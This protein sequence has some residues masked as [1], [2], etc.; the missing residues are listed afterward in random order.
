MP[1][2]TRAQQVGLFLLLTIVVLLA[3]T[4]AWLW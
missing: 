1:A 2:P 4:R 3:L